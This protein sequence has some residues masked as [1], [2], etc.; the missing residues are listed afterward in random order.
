MT[1]IQRLR[2]L[3]EMRT[4]MHQHLMLL[5]VKSG[6]TGLEKRGEVEAKVE[7]Y[8]DLIDGMDL[9]I[10]RLEGDAREQPG[11]GEDH[12]EWREMDEI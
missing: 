10:R 1:T 7:E 12:E 11:E 5:L 2:K 3:A 8:K 9:L 6:N 4:S